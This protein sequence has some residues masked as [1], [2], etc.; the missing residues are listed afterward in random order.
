M[1][2][3]INSTKEKTNEREIVVSI[4]TIVALILIF[5][6]TLIFVIFKYLGGSYSRYLNILNP[7]LFTIRPYLVVLF[8]ITLPILICVLFI[9]IMLINPKLRKHRFGLA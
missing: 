9:Y 2:S 6:S 8:I 3:L 5:I 4:S 7:L 1:D